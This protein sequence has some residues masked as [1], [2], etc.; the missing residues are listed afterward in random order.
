MQGL[1][2]GTP[3]CIQLSSFLQYFTVWIFLSF[4]VRAVL[5][6]ISIQV[7]FIEK[8]SSLKQPFLYMMSRHCVTGSH[9]FKTIHCSLLQVPKSFVYFYHSIVLE[10][11]ETNQSVKHILY[12]K[13]RYLSYNAA[14]T[15]N[16]QSQTFFTVAGHMCF[17]FHCTFGSMI[18]CWFS[19]TMTSSISLRIR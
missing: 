11:L 19:E 4:E 9:S 13:D 7:P 17:I 14:K 1:C 12:Q 18:L 2:K 16:L 10:M 15:Q 8:N 3:Y 6:K 5:D